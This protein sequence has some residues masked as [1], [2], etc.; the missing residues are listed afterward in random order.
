MPPPDLPPEFLARL[1]AVTGKRPRT[2]IDFILEHG[3]VTTEQLKELGYNHPPRAA[4]DVRELGIPLVTTRVAG[5]DGRSIGVYAF[6]KPSDLVTGLVGRTAISK[7][8]KEALI[9]ANGCRCAVCDYDFEQ[10]YLQVD[11]RVPVEVGGDVPDDERDIADYMLLDAACN[12]S[13][14]W[15]CEHCPN[16]TAK[17]VEVCKTCYWSSPTDYDHIATVGERRV[18]VVFHG[19][20]EL[21]HYDRLKD[22]AEAVGL[23]LADYL[24]ARE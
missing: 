2:V 15:S 3:S 23:S 22:E 5:P 10:R 11:H 18:A 6:G 20:D 9:E 8:F 7:Q 12:R 4:R 17:V 16:F 24:K 21:A 1:K 13:K 14:S 19:S